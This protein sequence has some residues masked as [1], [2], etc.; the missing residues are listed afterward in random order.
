MFYLKFNIIRLLFLFRSIL[1]VSATGFYKPDIAIHCSS[2]SHCPKEW[3]CC[4]QYG[5]CGL[6]PLCVTNCNPKF[7]FKQ[8]SCIAM[9]ALVPPLFINFDSAFNSY[10]IHKRDTLVEIA[11]PPRLNPTDGITTSSVDED[12][13]A[14]RIIS[15]ADFLVTHDS[16]EA[17]RMLKSYDFTHSGYTSI[18]SDTGELVLGMPKYSTGSSL[19]ASKAIQY[20]KV[21]ARLKTARSRGV[22]TAVVLMSATGDEID[23]EFLGSELNSVQTNYYSQGELIYSKMQ[24]HHI[25]TDTNQNYHT[26]D[27]D[28]DSERI[29]WVIDNK[30]VRTLYKRDT[31]DP[32]DKKYKYPQT[33]M[34]FEVAIWPGGSEENSLGT[35]SWAG[36]FI[37]WENSPDMS[38]NGQFHT[39]VSN[40][41]VIP[42][43]N[44]FVP[45]IEKCLGSKSKKGKSGH[46]DYTKVSYAYKGKKLNSFDE[47]SLITK[48]DIVPHI[49]NY[50]IHEQIPHEFP[51]NRNQ[52][53]GNSS[54]P[55][56]PNSEIKTN[57]KIKHP[58]A[59]KTDVA[60]HLTKNSILKDKKMIKSTLK[61]GDRIDPISETKSSSTYDN[62][63]FQNIT[64]TDNVQ[65]QTH[66]PTI[67]TT[68]EEKV[69]L[70]VQPTNEVKTE[71]TTEYFLES[72]VSSADFTSNESIIITTKRRRHF[73]R[74]PKS[75]T[76]PSILPSSIYDD[77]D[78][79]EDLDERSL[80]LS[81]LYHRNPLSRIRQYI[82]YLIM[83]FR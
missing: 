45:Q 32:I 6:G 59:T 12:L 70:S 20:G 56:N 74:H 48:C 16:N 28:W 80:G 55:L 49:S 33:P 1:S 8:D 9:P 68:Q 54:Q 61:I 43:F 24:T 65:T 63:S 47:S 2:D 38:N 30:I 14:R 72:F 83:N 19:K 21:S 79:D 4:S 27:I 40:L 69:Q 31:W 78:G 51:S 17:D 44:K 5:E 10:P 37:D 81:L 67:K 18:N 60:K 57:T 29:N 75:T 35:I 39:V 11:G 62:I 76:T 22:I 3:P 23:F 53:T 58:R 34:I 41:L 25:Q 66:Y 77:E 82:I 15:H 42:H 7:S 64:I 71:T 50:Q 73:L 26:Y 52:K 13:K 36:G 46:P